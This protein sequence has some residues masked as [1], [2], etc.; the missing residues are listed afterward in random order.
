V[1]RQRPAETVDIHVATDGQMPTGAPEYAR[2]KVGT[3]LH[4]A[5]EPVLAARVR[6]VHHGDPALRHPVVAQANL[7]VNGQPVRAQ[8]EGATCWEAIDLLQPRLRTRLERIAEQWED[9]RGG[10]PSREPHEWRHESEPTHRR[11]RYPRP[12][13]EREI[14]RH[15]AFTLPRCSIDDAARDMDQLDYD[16]HLFTET[17]TGRDSVLYRAGRTGYRLAQLTP[18][19]PEALAAHRLPVTISGHSAPL[20]STEEAVTRLNLVDLPFLFFQD[21][22]LA[23]GVVLYHRYDGPYGLITPAE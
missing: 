20:L 19:S 6:L 13:E 21:A 5:P 4:L 10:V 14:V 17:G 16:F 23:R 22:E 9:R 18:P 1:T 2:E 8:A 12:E 15:K 3:V 11:S 7:D